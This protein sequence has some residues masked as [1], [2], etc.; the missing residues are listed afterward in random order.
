MSSAQG[1]RIVHSPPRFLLLPYTSI[2]I[3][4]IESV[5]SQYRKFFKNNLSKSE[6]ISNRLIHLIIFPIID[7]MF[8]EISIVQL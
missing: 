7:L 6:I 5:Y 8:K 4:Y 2:H 1:N 3:L